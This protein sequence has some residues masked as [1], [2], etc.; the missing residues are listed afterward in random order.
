MKHQGSVSGVL[1][2]RPQSAEELRPQADDSPADSYVAEVRRLQDEMAAA[3]SAISSN[4]LQVLEESLWR[5]QVLCTSL[6]RLLH[7]VQGATVS[8]AVSR[9]MC[10]ATSALHNLN[11]TYAALVRQSGASADLFQGLCRSY[12]QTL[13]RDPA[14][15]QPSRCSLEV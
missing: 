7:V 13:R 8:P 2:E 1:W 5:Q 15:T 12:K 4:S 14:V 3:M 9:H 6:R 11:H 10:E